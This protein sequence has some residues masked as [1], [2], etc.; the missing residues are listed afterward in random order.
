MTFREM[1]RDAGRGA[2]IGIGMALMFMII[3]ERLAPDPRIWSGFII[4][5]LVAGFV[6]TL[7]NELV[8]KVMLAVYPR[9]CQSI[10]LELSVSY[11]VNVLL[12]FTL[13]NLINRVFSL[14]PWNQGFIFSLSLGVGWGSLMVTLF[15]IYKM[16]K[17][18]KLHLEIE[19]GKLAVIEERNRIARDLH[20]SISQ[21]LF[22]INL[23]LDTIQCLFNQNP[24]K[25]KEMLNL[26][27]E[28]VTETQ[29]DMRLMIY[30]LRPAA[31]TEKGFLETMEELLG[32]FRNRYGL[33]IDSQMSGNEDIPDSQSQIIFYRILQESLNNVVKHAKAT[34]VK[35]IFEAKDGA[36]ELAIEDNGIGFDPLALNREH[37]LGING[38]KERIAQAG[39][40]LAIHSQPG[41]GTIVRAKI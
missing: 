11:L 27:R 19:A 7:G 32:L 2:F 36:G 4:L 6:I 40:K 38:M 18:E 16:E 26:V 31:F 21:N 9:Y 37:H 13:F 8:S 12:F 10:W 5:G 24:D 35:V 34:S 23:H 33:A 1:I 30:E 3:F 14:T 41:G 29:A 22:G 28:I 17:D 25:A 20:D 39:G 15:F